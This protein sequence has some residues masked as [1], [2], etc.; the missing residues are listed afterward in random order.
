MAVRKRDNRHNQKRKHKRRAVVKGPVGVFWDFENL[1][2]RSNQSYK[3]A[4]A[5][6]CVGKRHGYLANFSAYFQVDKLGRACRGLQQ[7]SVTTV[8]TPHHGKKNVADQRMIEDMLAFS[9]NHSSTPGRKTFV[10]VSSDADF[11]P[12]ISKLRKQGHKIVIIYHGQRKEGGLRVEGCQ[13]IKWIKIQRMTK[14]LSGSISASES[15]SETDATS[16][17][18][19]D[20]GSDS[21][22]T[23]DSESEPEP[24]EG[25]TAYDMSEDDTD[26][27]DDVGVAGNYHSSPSDGEIMS[28][29][30]SKR[31][32]EGSASTE[33]TILPEVDEMANNGIDGDSAFTVGKSDGSPG[34]DDQEENGDMRG[35]N[36]EKNMLIDSVHEEASSLERN[37]MDDERE[38]MSAP[39]LND[40]TIFS[41]P[42]VSS[43]PKAASPIGVNHESNPSIAPA[44]ENIDY[45]EMFDTFYLTDDFLYDL[46]NAEQ[47][48][49]SCL[50]ERLPEAQEN[51]DD[52]QEV[53]TSEKKTKHIQ[54]G[55]PS[56]TESEAS[57][58]EVNNPSSTRHFGVYLP[59]IRHI[60]SMTQSSGN[61]MRR[62]KYKTIR[63]SL[64]NAEGG[65]DMALAAGYGGPG[66]Y[67]KG[68]VEAGVLL[69]TVEGTSSENPFV[70]LS[71]KSFDIIL[72]EI[73]QSSSP[74]VRQQIATV[75]ATSIMKE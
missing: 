61:S 39:V 18:S 59:L 73:R 49:I 27:E 37:E 60:G 47:H 3:Y 31:F 75:W 25:T 30:R 26:D 41:T 53:F 11:K 24:G 51:H 10:V 20:D 65:T 1:G 36:E 8:D 16:D 45:D 33:G 38:R 74:E 67:I 69:F 57:P 12:T 70:S 50:A 13:Q 15:E 58:V 32:R 55:T 2:S 28:R 40:K 29:D 66:R 54:S 72:S 46:F 19:S 22:L 71:D 5:I 62:L 4:S 6:G 64:R 44:I 9:R 7:A 68:G 63:R 48:A 23:S 35:D 21:D 34:Q 14:G 17:N 56:S 52:S 43:S 42:D